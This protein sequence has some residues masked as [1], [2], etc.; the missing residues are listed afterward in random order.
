MH[1]MRVVGLKFDKITAERFKEIDGTV[2]LKSNFNIGK[3]EKE[4]IKGQESDS[5]FSFE[6]TY[7]LDYDDVA[8]IEFSGEVFLFV[9][10]KIAKDLEKEK[11]V[12]PDEIKTTLLNFILFRTHVESL[13]LEEKL[14]IPFH[15]SSPRAA[16]NSKDSV[17]DSK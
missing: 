17:K 15:V 6:F 10:K 12:I 16:V 14:N 5:I 3:I 8:K 1:K 4:E 13:H 9:D 2:D 11:K 7:S